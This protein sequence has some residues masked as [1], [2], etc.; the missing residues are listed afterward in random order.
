[1]ILS[2]ILFTGYVNWRVHLRNASKSPCIQNS[3]SSCL[4]ISCDANVHCL[5]WDWLLL[6]HV[7]Y[8]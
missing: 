3:H 1:M 2:E 5:E 8:Q 4:W 7:Y 6:F